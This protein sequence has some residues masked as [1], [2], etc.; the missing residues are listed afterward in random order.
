VDPARQRALDFIASAIGADGGVPYL[1]GKASAGEP[2]VLSLA[3]GVAIDLGALAKLDLGWARYLLPAALS[4]TP[5]GQA[6]SD[7]ACDWILARRGIPTGN[8][9]VVV[10]M[11]GDIP[12]WSWVENTA[13]WVEPTSYAVISLTRAGR[14]S[15]QRVTDG[16]AM[17][18]DRQCPDGGWN[19]G[20]PKVLGQAQDSDLVPTGW[21]TLALLPGPVRDRGAERLLD[22][23]EHPS[24]SG[25][26]LAILARQ[27]CGADLVDLRDR[28]TARQGDDGSFSGRCDW[29]ALAACALG[30]LEDGSHVFA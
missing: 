6:L 17:L 3:A 13:S 26:A 8:D 7:E 24:T 5:A 18:T 29:T 19:Y 23:R 25:L 20:N 16:R 15:D 11:D 2:T 21:A 4:R 1:R 28:L 12:A 27:A 10:D 9:R 14:G 22:A 30:A